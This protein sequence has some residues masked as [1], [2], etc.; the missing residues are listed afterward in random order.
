MQNLRKQLE[1]DHREAIKYRSEGFLEGLLPALDSFY[2]ALSVT[3]NGQ[4]AINYQLGFQYIYNQIEHA[5]E[6]EGVKSIEPKVGDPFDSTIMHAVD[7]AEG[8]EDGKI[9]KVYSKGYKLYDRLVR[10]V[11]VLVSKKK[12]EPK[13]EE[14]Q[15]EPSVDEGHMA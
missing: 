3:P 14:T 7:V 12:S 13:T 9:L 10:P 5:L 11:M 8:E 15:P 6:E 2:M 4:E 1:N